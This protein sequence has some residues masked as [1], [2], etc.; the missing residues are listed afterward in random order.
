MKE[1]VDVA[2]QL[3][4]D[5]LREEAQAENHEFINSL[6][7]NKTKIIKQQVKAQTS[8][9]MSK[10]EKYVTDTLGAKVLVRLTNQHQTS[11]AVASSLLEL[12]LKKILM[13]KMEENK[14]IDRSK[15]QFQETTVIK[16]KMK[17]PPLD[18]TE[19]QRER[20]QARKLSQPMNQLIRRAGQQVLKKK[21]STSGSSKGTKSQP[22]SSGKSV[23][24]EEPVFEVADSDMPQDQE[25][26]LGDNENEPRSEI[27]STRDWFKKPTPPQEPTDLDWNIGKNT[28]EGPTKKWL[29]TLAASTSTDKSLKDFDELMSTPIDFYGYILNGLKIKNLNQEILLGPAFRILK[30][31]CSNYAEL[32]YDFEEC[33]KALSEKLDWENPEGGDYL[34]DLSKPLPLI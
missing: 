10:L 29:M 12:E 11:Y 23:Q 13:D 3:K 33:Y 19:G 25:G 5:K 27:A 24:S 9:I 20:D 16:I 6:N 2:V 32:E 7:S 8:K 17:N 18:Q 4:S 14:S 28:Q 31:T 22:K 30:D 26:N 15:S 34:F 21:D 1:E